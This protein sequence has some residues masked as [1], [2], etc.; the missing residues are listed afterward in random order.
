MGAIVKATR[1]SRGH[2]QRYTLSLTGLYNASRECVSND[3]SSYRHSYLHLLSLLPRA[4]VASLGVK[5]VCGLYGTPLT[6]KL[7]APPFRLCLNPRHRDESS[8]LR[9]RDQPLPGPY[10][11]K[12]ASHWQ[13]QRGSLLDAFPM[14]ICSA[15]SPNFLPTS[16]QYGQAFSVPHVLHHVEALAEPIYT[17][18]LAMHDASRLRHPVRLE[19]CTPYKCMPPSSVLHGKTSIIAPQPSRLKLES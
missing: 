14:T 4:G 6:C 2:E 10:L 17:L 3:E 13:S 19:H 11:W 12:T 8:K 1:N 16:S 9:W 15:A 5:H 18:Q 7:T